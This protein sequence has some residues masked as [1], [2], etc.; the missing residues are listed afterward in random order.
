MLVSRYPHVTDNLLISENVETRNHR[1]G[2]HSATLIKSQTKASLN[3]VVRT[4]LSYAV[5][6]FHCRQSQPTIQHANQ[7]PEWQKSKQQ[8]AQRAV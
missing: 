3:R 4:T 5:K 2:F 6:T 8:V 1:A 7:N